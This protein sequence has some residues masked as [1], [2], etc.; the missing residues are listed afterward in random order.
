[1]NRIPYDYSGFRLSRLREPRF[2]HLLYLL[3]WVGYFILYFLTENLIPAESCHVMHCALDDMIPFC[4]YF[5]V[6]YCFWYVFVFGSLLYY[7]VY[8]VQSFTKL[9]TFIIATQVI[10]MAV[11]IIY[12]SRQDMRP[13]VFVRDNAF[14]HL[15][16]FIYSFDTSTGVCPSLHVGYSLGIASVFLKNKNAPKVWKGITVF[17]VIMISLSTAFVKQHSMVDVFWALPLGVAAEA[18][19]YGKDYWLPKL[20]KNKG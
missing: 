10:A 11:Y 7:L 2:H 20:R 3:G 8:D 19:T 12:P 9:Q 5:L 4:E 15:M 13:D 6:F 18:I 14:T 1:M 16:A 17:L